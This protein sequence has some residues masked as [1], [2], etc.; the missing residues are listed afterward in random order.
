M[1]IQLSLAHID[2]KQDASLDDL[3]APS[4][5]PILNA[6]RELIDGSMRELYIYGD[7][8]A[9]KTHLLSAIYA[10]FLKKHGMAIFLSLGEFLGD[11][12]SALV[13][14]EAF[15]LIIID[16]VHLAVSHREWQEALFHLINR[17]RNHNTKLIFSSAASINELGFE[18][19]DLTTRLSQGLGLE[20]PN[21]SL[22]EDRK[23]TLKSL[24][25]QKGWQIPEV[26]FEHLLNDGPHHVGDMLKVLEAITPLFNYRY[27]GKLPQKIIE[28]IKLAI[29][30]QS[31][32]VELADIH[33]DDDTATTD[34]QNHL[35][36]F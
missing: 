4:F 34:T 17:A 36:L 30:E 19:T 9:G 24:L 7:T 13:G 25:K 12:V 32:M 2:I 14:L 5:A 18:V 11:D 31:L 21:G 8:G 6:V 35:T 1:P 10:E 33:L 16:D 20:L 22:Y 26:I 27:R 23:A 28:E 3:K 15:K 29:N